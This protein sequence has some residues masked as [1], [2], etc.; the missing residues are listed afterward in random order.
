M[1]KEDLTFIDLDTDKGTEPLNIKERAKTGDP[2]YTE[3][4][5]RGSNKPLI[6]IIILL[7]L[8]T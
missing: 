8:Q 5:K 4:Q 6:A 7:I 1:S 2:G 3:F